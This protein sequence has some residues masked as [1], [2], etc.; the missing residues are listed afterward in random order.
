MRILVDQ[1]TSAVRAFWEQRDDLVLVVGAAD[2]DLP[3]VLKIV[4]GLEAHLAFAWC[5][6]FSQPFIEPG[7][8]ADAIVTDIAT[9]RDAVSTTLIQDGKLGWPAFPD[10]MTNPSVEPVDRLR[11]AVVY[12]RELVPVVPGGV[13][14]FGLLP[15]ENRQPIGYAALCQQ[16]IRHQL[17][18]P[19]CARVRFMLRDDPTAPQLLA[20]QTMPRVRALRADFGP[21][22]LE[23]ALKQ[24]IADPNL[25]EA[26]RMMSAIVAAGIQEAHGRPADAQVLYRDALDHFGREG[27]AAVAAL[28]AHGVAS[29]KQALGDLEAA[30]R[31]WLAALEAGLAAQP[32]ALPVLLN[33]S[34]GLIMLVAR[35][36]R[37]LEAEAYAVMSQLLAK[38]LFMPTVQAE[39]EERCGIAQSRQGK[40][41]AA[42]QSWRAAIA[43]ADAA[44]DTPRAI[45]V[46]TWL[47][48][49]LK[50]QE[51]RDAEVRE[52]A[53]D[54]TR[55]QHVAA[56]APQVA[57]RA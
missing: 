57:G 17:P 36:G 51:G 53:N 12:V 11:A 37:W 14:V 29:C 52:L 44:E 54:L 18:F 46:R 19:W 3:P 40:F 33:I 34:L 1:V 5:W 45:S 47:R 23:V 22:A 16:L 28:A 30:E 6:V 55:L 48:N 42:E 41:A 24:E 25:P 43:T 35:K 7:A 31:I 50:R 13:T 20:L 10:N 38:V 49:L 4:E 8:Y 15:T 26:R 27:N 9:K 56:K 21:A 39:A 2:A 32:P